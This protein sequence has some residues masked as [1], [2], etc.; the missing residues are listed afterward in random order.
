M[1]KLDIVWCCWHRTNLINP[2]TVKLQARSNMPTVL[3]V[4]ECDCL[5]STRTDEDRPWAAALKS[6][7]LQ[8]LSGFYHYHICMPKDFVPSSAS[9]KCYECIHSQMIKL[10][11]EHQIYHHENKIT[12]TCSSSLIWW[13]QENGLIPVH[14]TNIFQSLSVWHAITYMM[15]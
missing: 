15:S 2:H 5:F 13:R 10:A 9:F 7:F 1:L 8:E 6:Q 4:V 3:F 14:I 11:H 12:N